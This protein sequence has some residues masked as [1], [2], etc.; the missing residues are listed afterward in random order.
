M[1]RRK[2]ESSMRYPMDRIDIGAV[3]DD[4]RTGRLC[5]V[6]DNSSRQPAASV[7]TGQRVAKQ[8]GGVPVMQS[9][10]SSGGMVITIPHSGGLTSRGSGALSP[11]EDNDF[12]HRPTAA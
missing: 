3:A 8:S 1:E 12:V 10:Q 5:H 7:W 11:S 6:R 2:F 4:G 9:V